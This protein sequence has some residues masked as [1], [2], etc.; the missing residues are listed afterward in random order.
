VT[1]WL[2]VGHSR[3]IIRHTPNICY[4]NSGFVQRG[5]QL[6]HHI[7]L[8][9]GKEA[10][11]Y[12]AKFQKEDAFGRIIERV[13]WA[14]NHPDYDR[15]EAPDSPRFHYG[16]SRALYKV[17]FTSNVTAAENTIDDN[18]AVD[19]AKV[20]LPA[21]DAALFPKKDTPDTAQEAA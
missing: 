16:R 2:I 17:Y 14:W 11:F 1:L 12:T 9:G 19:F 18:P 6:R 8:G 5:S 21:I 3:D 4:P 10:V 13:F 15:W 20:M 7:D